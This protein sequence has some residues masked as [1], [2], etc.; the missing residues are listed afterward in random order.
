[1]TKQKLD[2]NYQEMS[3]ELETILLDLQQGGIDVDDAMKKY[4]RG[5]K[6]IT[7]LE[8][9]LKVAEITVTKLKVQFGDKEKA[10]E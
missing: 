9:Y 5:L 10:G 1:M 7:A 2:L 3:A 4:A 6:L 8:E